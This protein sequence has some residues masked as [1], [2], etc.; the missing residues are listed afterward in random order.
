MPSVRP[1]YMANFPS[2]LITRKNKLYIH[3]L[4]GADIELK[5]ESASKFF[6]ADGSDQQIEFQTDDNG[7]FIGTWYVGWGVRREM[8]KIE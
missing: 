6:F 4:R 3:P 7:K 8:V 2:E 1:P 5:Q